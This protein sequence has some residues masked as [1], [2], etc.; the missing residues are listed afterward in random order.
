MKQHFAS[1]KGEAQRRALD[2]DDTN[3]KA[4][5]RL[6]KVDEGLGL[7]DDAET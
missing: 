6:R 5:H 1:A 4:Q 2:S 7:T 3:E